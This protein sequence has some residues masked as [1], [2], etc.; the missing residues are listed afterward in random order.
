MDEWWNCS[1]NASHTVLVVA[2]ADFVPTST[3]DLCGVRD[4]AWHE[5]S[6][7]VFGLSGDSLF[8]HAAY[9]GMYDI[10]FPLVTDFH[11]QIAESYGSFANEWEGHR[12]IQNGQRSSSTRGG[13]SCVTKQ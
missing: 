4:A 1:P 7:A 2:P 10:P 12:Q 9:A 8:S 13:Q 6:L 11:G 5:Q 3:A